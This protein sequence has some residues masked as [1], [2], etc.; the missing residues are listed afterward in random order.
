MTSRA[1][2]GDAVAAALKTAAKIARGGPVS[3]A[4]ARVLARFREI[5]RQT[6]E[7]VGVLSPGPVVESAA[8][9]TAEEAAAAAAAVAD[10][11]RAFA[12]RAKRR[13][14]DGGRGG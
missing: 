9:A 7:V 6:D 13:R 5:E 4:P 8:P 2:L 12:E 1:A 3:G 10:A 14:R 11:E